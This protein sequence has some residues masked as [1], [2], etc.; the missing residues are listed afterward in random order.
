MPPPS[1]VVQSRLR[2]APHRGAGAG[3]GRGW[4]GA[5]GQNRAP[6]RPQGTA[7]PATGPRAPT[8]AGAGAAGSQVDRL[9][10]PSLRPAVTSASILLVGRSLLLPA[11]SVLFTADQLRGTNGYRGAAFKPGGR[12]RGGR[13]WLRV[14]GLLSPEVEA[15]KLPLSS[16]SDDALLGCKRLLQ[17]YNSPERSQLIPSP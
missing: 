7:A 10:V 3:L 12:A 1:P 16:L 8:L 5:P 11:Q 4:A 13:G 17:K 9:F 6:P 2:E 15:T 14:S